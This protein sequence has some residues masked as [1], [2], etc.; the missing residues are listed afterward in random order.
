MWQLATAN[1][2]QV[3]PPWENLV[4]DN[5]NI[6]IIITTT[7]N[8]NITKNIKIGTRLEYSYLML[9]CLAV[10]WPMVSWPL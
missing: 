2:L 8:N 6:I 10:N 9:S 4:Q 3:N 5:Y 7:N 1:L